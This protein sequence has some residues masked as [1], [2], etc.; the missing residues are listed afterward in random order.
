MDVIQW[1]ANATAEKQ[2]ITS[3]GVNALLN[4]CLYPSSA[5]S[6][7]SALA[8]SSLLV[9]VVDGG[10]ESRNSKDVLSAFYPGA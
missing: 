2:L 1:M 3:S 8:I 4:S 6:C 7:S 10:C 5:R 9:M